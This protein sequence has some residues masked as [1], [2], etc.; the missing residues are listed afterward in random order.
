MLTAG[1]SGVGAAGMLLGFS[2]GYAFLIAALVLMGILGGGYHPAASP[3]ITAATEPRDRG[4]ALGLHVV[5]GSLSY[6]AAPLLGVAAAS[7][8]GWRF[9]FLLFSIPVIILGAYIFHACSRR[10]LG[11]AVKGREAREETKGRMSPGAT[12][13]LTAFVLLVTAMGASLASALAFLPLYL[14]DTFG[15][16]EK[17]AAALLALVFSSGIWAAPLAGRISDRFGRKRVAVAVAAAAAAG[18]LAL[19]RVPYG[20]GLAALLLAIGAASFAR[21]PAAEAYIVGM[22]PD[23]LRS[24]VL[25]I[26]FFAGM[27]GSGVLTPLLGGWIDAYGFR[28]SF[29]ILGWGLATVV[30]ACSLVLLA[31]DRRA[32]KGSTG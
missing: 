28:T 7:V 11:G 31:A 23:S 16:S 6:F 19:P 32:G 1:I 30:A 13:E 29:T 15:S 9:T 21:M 3:L 27:E 24:T 17:T 10:S 25:G 20:F 8:L 18:L 5:G 4:K 14:V 22:V 12:I 26:Y 2:S